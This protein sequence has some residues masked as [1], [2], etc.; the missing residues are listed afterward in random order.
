VPNP[1]ERDITNM[2]FADIC[3]NSLI[4]VWQR[5]SEQILDYEN[6]IYTDEAVASFMPQGMVVQYIPNGLL[7]FFGQPIQDEEDFDEYGF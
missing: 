7:I 6:E 5:S 3:E 1:Y 2:Q 4:D